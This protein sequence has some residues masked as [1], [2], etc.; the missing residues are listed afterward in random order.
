MTNPLTSRGALGIGSGVLGGVA[1]AA[2]FAVATLYADK[3]FIFL[4]YLAPIPLFMAGL[5]AGY[6][7]G[8]IASLAGAGGLILATS[9]QTAW[10]YTILIALPVAI[11]VTMAMRYKLSEDGQAFWYPEGRLLT[12][13]TAYPCLFFLTAFGAAEQQ[14]SGGLLQQTLDALPQII[15]QF[16]KEMKVEDIAPLKSA[17]EML[18]NVFPAIAGIS[19]ILI[20]LLCALVAQSSL[21]QQGWLLR[22]SLSWSELRLPT[23]LIIAAAIAGLMAFA[24]APYDYIGTN[25][26]AILCAPIFIAG[27]AIAHAYAATKKTRIFILFLLYV[28]LTFLPWLAVLVTLLGA[29]DQ[30]LDFRR[31]LKKL[32]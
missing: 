4:A 14:E 20:V 5:G 10:V 9:P 6:V 12:A 29:L 31:R 25:L 11:L 32:N 26:G 13:L 3:G 23:T 18:A 2:L 15:D 19:W 28:L 1:S 22:S 7:S 8:I 30:G 24:P 21:R 16:S 17:L 27:L